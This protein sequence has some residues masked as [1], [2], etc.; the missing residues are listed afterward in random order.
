MFE[1]LIFESI[2]NGKI[3]RDSYK[4]HIALLFHHTRHHIVSCH[5]ETI[6]VKMLYLWVG[7]GGFRLSSIK[8]LHFPIECLHRA[9]GKVTKY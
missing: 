8:N 1:V 3:E 6:S 9:F 4:D 7:I 2:P 5:F